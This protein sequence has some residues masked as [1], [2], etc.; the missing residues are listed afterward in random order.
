MIRLQFRLERDMLEPLRASLPPALGFQASERI[1]VLA[2]ES[3]GGVTPD[4]LVG[5][6][7]DDV[8]PAGAR[9]TFVEAAV[10]ALLER[11]G[12]LSESEILQHLCLTEAA[13]KRSLT[14]LRRYGAIQSG[15]SSKCEVTGG[16]SCLATEVVAIELKLRRW[17]D[18]LAQAQSY[19]HFADRTYVV[20]D[21][22]QTV[23]TFNM[24]E[25]FTFSGVGLIMQYGPDSRQLIEARMRTVVTPGRVVA[26]WKLRNVFASHQRVHV[27]HP[28]FPA[29]GFQRRTDL[30]G[31][32]V[33][34]RRRGGNVPGT[35]LPLRGSLWV[36]LTLQR[37]N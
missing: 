15:L 1:A 29:E 24:L 17:R 13:A 3:V 23:P 35:M 14:N 2:E 11:E 36:R 28:T 27:V 16:S 25:A 18:A 30:T 21:A 6:W 20:L 32:L 10:L 7:R 19:C 12:P 9:P 37:R 26:A 33:V 31:Y 8:P 22:A 4:V 34:V 5:I